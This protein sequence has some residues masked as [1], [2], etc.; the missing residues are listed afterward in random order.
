MAP[1]VLLLGCAQ[2]DG[3]FSGGRASLTVEDILDRCGAAYLKA[4]TFHARGLLRDYRAPQRKVLPIR[5]DY[6]RPDRCRL[7]IGMDVGLVSGSS[8]WTYRSRVGRFRS[9][10]QISRTPIETS[11][12]LLSDG[13]SFLQPALLAK[14]RAAL[15]YGDRRRFGPWESGGVAWIAERP[16]YVVS[17]YGGRKASRWTVWIDQDEFLVRAWRFESVRTEQRER[18]VLGCTYFEAV[19]DAALPPDTFRVRPPDP[20]SIPQRAAPAE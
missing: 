7:Q 11:A 12:Y 5:W 17:R 6:A 13:V 18:T 14:G 10:R 4:E 9:H 20:I 1:I 2:A 16:C 8:W 19:A 15:D 3:G